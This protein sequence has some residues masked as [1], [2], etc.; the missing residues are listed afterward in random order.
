M[1]EPIE[2]Y[3][4][5]LREALRHDPLLARRLCDEV[6]DHLAEL[7]AANRSQGMTEH[8]A[9]EAAVR[10]FGEAG[11]LARQFQPFSLPLKLL[12]VAGAVATGL[13]ALWLCF[14]VV[15]VLPA[16]DP[17]RIGLWT[18]IAVA[19]FGYAALTLLSVVRG[20]R[21]AWLP[22]SVGAL[23]LAALAFGGYEVA[24]MVRAADS[25]AHFEGYLLLM[26]AILAAQGLCALVYTA[27]SWA[28]ARRVRAA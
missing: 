4:R 6:A 19:F 3:L 13:I 7:S 2:R 25:G 21:P 15:A 8:D 28:I 23:S 5:A 1:A 16:R 12:V 20:P 9:Q 27:L 17:Q 24:A 22:G 10:R 26:G 18:S 11:A 14:V